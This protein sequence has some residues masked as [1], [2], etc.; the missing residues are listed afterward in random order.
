MRRLFFLFPL[1]VLAALVLY[2][3]LGIGRDPSRL[4]SVLIG[5][6]APAFTLPA[7]SG[8]DVGLSSDAFRGQVTLLSVFASWCVS[9]RIEHPELLKVA[10][11]GDVRLVGLNWKDKPGDGARWLAEL[12]D[13]YAAIGD[14]AEGRVA[15]DYGVSGAPETFVID[16]KGI[17]RD[18]IIGP[19]TPQIWEQELAP[20]IGELKNEAP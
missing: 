13:P 5:K 8:R 20:L 18:K 11:R 3:A 9:C 4:P 16:R 7:I 15:L 2:F 10:A 17:I 1:V 19:I 14:D 12:G 6:P